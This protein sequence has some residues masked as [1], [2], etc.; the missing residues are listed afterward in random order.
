MDVSS[1]LGYLL[2]IKDPYR[3]LAHRHFHAEGV[4]TTETKFGFLVSYR[5]QCF[6][7]IVDF[8]QFKAERMLEDANQRHFLELINRE[9]VLPTLRAK[10]RF[11]QL[12]HRNNTLPA[13]YQIVSD[14]NGQEHAEYDPNFC[15]AE[16]ELQQKS[17]SRLGC[18]VE[19][20]FIQHHRNSPEIIQRNYTIMNIKHRKEIESS[21]LLSELEEALQVSVA[22]RELEIEREHQH[23]RSVQ[24]VRGSHFH[25]DARSV[26]GSVEISWKFVKPTSPGVFLQ[27]FTRTEGY[28]AGQLPVEN[29][30][31]CIADAQQD[32]NTGLHLGLGKDHFFTFVLLRKAEK[33]VEIIETLRFSL[34]LPTH[35]EVCRLDRIAEQL[36]KRP[37]PTSTLSPK[38]QAAVMELLS[39]VEFDES[40]SKLEKQLIEQI[41]AGDYS[42]E[43]REEKL[44]RLRDVVESVRMHHT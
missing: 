16:A 30:G 4:F 31:M 21:S 1:I 37:A 35:E 20:I 23:R 43:E 40:V 18:A 11:F 28:W 36:S 27:G 42:D 39:Y 3:N 25:I 44:Q 26:G 17:Y 14:Q 33:G 38:S 2:D 22:Y 6:F 15:K 41:K 32:G 9:V 19:R 29:N 8:E 24:T 7:E 12:R 34:R 5:L 13:L 10:G